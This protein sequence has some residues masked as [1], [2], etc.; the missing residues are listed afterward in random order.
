[1]TAAVVLA[2]SMA[3]Y[4]VSATFRL[5]LPL[6]GAELYRAAN[7]GFFTGSG[8]ASGI[9]REYIPPTI[10]ELRSLSGSLRRSC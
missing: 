10:S 7:N 9:F 4:G 5:S 8:R 6:T 2:A 1:V 3:L